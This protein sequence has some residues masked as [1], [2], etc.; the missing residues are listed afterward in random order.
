MSVNFP[1]SLDS[2]TN[3]TGTDTVVAVDHAA[4]HS[5]ANDILE[6]LEVKVGINASAVT[7]THDYKLSEVISSDKAV[8]KSATQTLTNK[9]IAG[10]SNTLT[11]RLANDVSGNL[12][13]T[14]LNSGTSAS[15]STFWR[16]DGTWAAQSGASTINSSIPYTTLGKEDTGT[17]SQS[18]ATT[19]TMHIGSVII[20]FG[21]TVNTATFNVP[22]HSGAGTFK[23]GFYTYDG[24][25]L[26]LNFTS[27][28]VTGTGYKTVTLGSPV[29]LTA[30]M[31]WVGFV[32]VSGTFNVQTYNTST[33]Q[34]GFTNV[35]A[36][37]PV[38]EG[39]LSV[40][41]GT[42]PSTITPSA[43]SNASGRTAIIRI[44]N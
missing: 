40:T 14:N 39:T 4:Q 31:Y 33:D 23:V 15:A 38:L 41:S 25:S 20:P 27:A 43:I 13:V 35:P 17:V 16:G 29:V 37:K 28:S 34:R 8:G 18:I 36:G 6:A 2:L 44:D 30:G 19:T 12:P 24:S 22:V 1:T 42:L 32:G 11:V 10:A 21:I 5:N 7:T 26:A 9:T 3:P